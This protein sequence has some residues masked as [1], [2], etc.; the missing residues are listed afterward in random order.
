[1]LIDT[2]WI[3]I[4][5]PVSNRFL[6]FVY[7]W[8]LLPVWYYLLLKWKS[9]NL[10]K[11]FPL[12][13]WWLIHNLLDIMKT[14]WAEGNLVRCFSVGISNCKQ[15]WNGNSDAKHQF[16]LPS[17]YSSANCMSNESTVHTVSAM[18]DS[19][20]GI[21]VLSTSSTPSML[22]AEPLIPPPT[23]VKVFTVSVFFCVGLK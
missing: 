8:Y 2:S 12:W 5:Q 9:N 22:S 18:S 13:F 6:E 23:S 7:V 11:W 15:M 10:L 1:M 19:T 3:Q 16:E 14:R 17:W 20:F 21:Y 4:L